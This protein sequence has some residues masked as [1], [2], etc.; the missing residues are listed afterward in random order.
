MDKISN[1]RAYSLLYRS[2]YAL[3][4]NR[5]YEDP[6]MLALAIEAAEIDKKRDEVYLRIRLRLDDAAKQH[7]A[8]DR[9]QE[10]EDD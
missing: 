4:T 2:G 10:E 8:E 7:E 6:E 9:E 1:Y 3:P 5:E